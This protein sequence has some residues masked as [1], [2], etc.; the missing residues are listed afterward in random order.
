MKKLLLTLLMIP[1]LSIAAVSLKGGIDCG[2]WLDAR[3]NK[4]A[5][6]LENSVQG[7]A[8]GYA[9]GSEFDIWMKPTEI[10]PSQLFYLVDRDCRNEPSNN[11]WKTLYNI[12]LDRQFPTN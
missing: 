6:A 2:I 4:N 10:S 9:A 5:Q 7:F 3:S 1:T 8:N 11:V 12:F